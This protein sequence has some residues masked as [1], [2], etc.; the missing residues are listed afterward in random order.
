MTV[1][2]LLVAL[3][4]AGC[5]GSDDPFNQPKRQIQ[6]EQ[7]NVSLDQSA[8]K[9]PPPAPA[10]APASTAATPA[11]N[12]GAVPPPP[13]PP[14]AAG[15]QNAAPPPPPADAQAKPAGAPPENVVREEAKVGAGK[16]GR[17]YEPGLVTTPV[18]AYFS[19]RERIVFEIQIPQAMKLYK[20][21]NEHGPKTQEEFMK[22]IKEQGVRLPDLPDG[23][24]Y[25]YDP[26]TEQLMVERPKPQ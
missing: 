22:I 17:G 8:P 19:A 20:A 2:V 23:H 4:A 16:R 9:A 25:V 26:A 5:N 7:Y 12:P 3:A 1:A 14:P 24:R 13:P 10:A 6:T 21:Q 15:G 18:A 11:A